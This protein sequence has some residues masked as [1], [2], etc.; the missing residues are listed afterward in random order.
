MIFLYRWKVREG[1]AQFYPERAG[2]SAFCAGADRYP[3][4]LRRTFSV[5]P[6]PGDLSGIS[7][8]DRV[9]GFRN[10]DIDAGSKRD[11]GWT[12]SSVASK[13]GGS[14]CQYPF[15]EPEP[16]ITLTIPSTARRT[17]AVGAYDSRSRTYADF[18][19]RGI[20]ETDGSGRYWPLPESMW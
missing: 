11:S 1:G 12:L 4:V 13:R 3:A 17:V 5:Q 2:G 20:P 14:Q 16:Y 19:G 6:V 9:C 7:S 8:A 15:S 10:L 18:S